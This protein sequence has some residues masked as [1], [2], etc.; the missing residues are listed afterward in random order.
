MY[1][2]LI[3]VASVLALTGC[4]SILNEK[5]QNVNVST[6]NGSQVEGTVNGQL[7]KAPGVVALIRENKSK[8]FVANSEN[9]KGETAV[10]KAIDTAFFV[11]I[12]SG[13]SG[14]TTDYLSERMWKYSD[15]IVINCK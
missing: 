15:N 14:S 9:C 7:F 3:L 5:T 8:V 4:A 12:V 10:D 1:K 11:N 6:S 13:G 2:N